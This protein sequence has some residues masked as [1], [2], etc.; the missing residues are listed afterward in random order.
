MLTSMRFQSLCPSANQLLAWDTHQHSQAWHVRC[1]SLGPPCQYPCLH[2]GRVVEVLVVV[3]H[4]LGHPVHYGRCYIIAKLLVRGIIH[5]LHLQQKHRLTAGNCRRLL[6][7][8]VWEPVRS[9]VLSRLKLKSS[10]PRADF[11]A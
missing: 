7:C 10:V 3:A 11:C 2:E 4:A 8:A 9:H 1:I 5:L 6:C